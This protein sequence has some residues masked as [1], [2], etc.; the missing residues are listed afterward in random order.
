MICCSALKFLLISARSGRPLPREKKKKLFVGIREVF[1]RIGAVVVGP[2]AAHLQ[3]HEHAELC[4]TTVPV[5][6]QGVI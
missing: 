6:W 4:V 2:H 1:E 5:V 3:V